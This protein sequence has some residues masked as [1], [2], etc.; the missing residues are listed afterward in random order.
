MSWTHLGTSKPVAAKAHRCIWCGQTIL[1]GE[2]HVYVRG[3]FEGDFQVN[4]YHNECDKAAQDYFRE[5]GDDG[6]DPYISDRPALS[7]EGCRE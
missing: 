2:Q 6:F 4:R 3:V 1:Q 5:Y 7:E